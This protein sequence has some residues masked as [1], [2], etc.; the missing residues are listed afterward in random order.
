MA[1][2]DRHGSNFEP[3]V[4][5]AGRLFDQGQLIQVMLGYVRSQD[6]RPRLA[7][8]IACLGEAHVA[9]AG[10]DVDGCW[11]LRTRF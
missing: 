5:F 4:D 2:N 11:G 3:L 6:R 7:A 1:I 9:S 10:A 8:L